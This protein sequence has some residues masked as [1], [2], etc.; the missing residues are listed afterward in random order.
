[1]FV[2]RIE[3]GLGTSD[4][5]IAD[6]LTFSDN[7]GVLLSDSI[8]S[9]IGMKNINAPSVVSTLATSSSLEEMVVYD[10]PFFQRRS[11]A[12]LGRSG[13]TKRRQIHMG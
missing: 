1:M 12:R 6:R 7:F 8:C 11:R 9:F 5:S 3:L 2:H 10:L 4:K 13:K